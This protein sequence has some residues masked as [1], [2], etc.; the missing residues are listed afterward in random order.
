MSPRT[1]A[2]LVKFRPLKPGGRIALVAPASPFNRAEFEAGVAELRELGLEPVFE[3][4]IFE[5]QAFTA[6]RPIV[7]ALALMRAFDSLDADA[8][9]AVRGGYGSVELLPLLDADRI[10]RS[11]TAFVGYSDVTSL[12]SWINATVGLTSV[13][14]PMIDGRVA[15]GP[16]AYD[17]VTFLRSLSLESVGELRH[18]GLETL[19]S[20]TAVGTIVG[21]TLTQ[22]LASL[23]TP[24]AFAPPDRHVLFIDEVGERPYRLHR[25]LTQLR[26]SG[27]MA[28]ASALVF[29]QL[30]RCDEP[31]GIVTAIDVVK[32]VT[33]GFPG[34]VLWG[35]PSGHTTTP[36]VSMPL[37]VA[38][39]VLADQA[40]PRLV[41]DEAA[42]A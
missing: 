28:R 16:T 11:R 38:T 37:G 25:M 34:P 7:R 21:G 26:L 30:P 5:R 39:R 24:F 40:R 17:P 20:G 27:R 6:G 33:A 35:F 36:L 14:G 19:Q 18:D 42:A 23:D 10:R 32:D 3:D 29:G 22:L 41:F 8:V 13:H 2:G 4:T 9:M 12:H 31:G 15:K 1:A